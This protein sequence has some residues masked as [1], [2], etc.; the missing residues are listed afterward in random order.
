[1]D[2]L[3]KLG[4]S[5]QGPSVVVYFTTSKLLQMVCTITPQRGFS[6]R[7]LTSGSVFVQPFSL[8][9]FVQGPRGLFLVIPGVVDVRM[10]QI[11]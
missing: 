5:V 3:G 10:P 4:C 2:A 9:F 1:M 6:V 8:P 7:H 11:V